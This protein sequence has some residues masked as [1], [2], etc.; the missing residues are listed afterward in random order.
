MRQLRSELNAKLF[1]AKDASKR[2]IHKSETKLSLTKV[3]VVLEDD[4]EPIDLD[5]EKPEVND[6]TIDE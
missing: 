6:E 2:Q 5:E 4:L 3:C 1:Y